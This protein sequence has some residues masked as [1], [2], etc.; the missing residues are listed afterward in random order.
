[1]SKNSLVN[2]VG[3][4]HNEIIPHENTMIIRHRNWISLNVRVY[5]IAKVTEDVGCGSFGA[6]AFHPAPRPLNAAIRCCWKSRIA[7]FNGQQHSNLSP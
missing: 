7:G 4:V 6:Y 1:M 2:I 3:M 5:H